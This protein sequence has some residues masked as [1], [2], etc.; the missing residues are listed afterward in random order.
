[1]NEEILIIYKFAIQ[2][3]FPISTDIIAID[4][5]PITEEPITEEQTTIA[6]I[7]KCST[8][9]LVNYIFK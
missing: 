8:S 4:I 6:E 5:D 2:Y 3:L 9:E 7:G 1:M